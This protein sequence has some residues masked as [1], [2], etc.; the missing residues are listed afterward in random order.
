MLGFDQRAH[1]MFSICPVVNQCQH[2]H[3]DYGQADG[4]FH[5]HLTAYIE[6][7]ETVAFVESQ[8]DAHQR[9]ASLV[10]LASAIAV[11]RRGYRKPFG[12]H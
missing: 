10:A 11:L 8:K 6:S 12:E 1:P 2:N 4:R 5:F 3:N 9:G 7:L